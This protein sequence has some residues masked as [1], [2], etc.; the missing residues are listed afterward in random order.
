MHTIDPFIKVTREGVRISASPLCLTAVRQD[1]LHNAIPGSA[2]LRPACAPMAGM[3][4]SCQGLLPGRGLAPPVPLRQCSL[5]RSGTAFAGQ[6]VL[7]R[8]SARRLHRPRSQR[9]LALR[10]YYHYDAVRLLLAIGQPGL[11]AVSTSYCRPRSSDNVGVERPLARQRHGG[12]C[13][14]RCAASGDCS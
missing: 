5:N 3:A 8:P 7:S 9:V 2:V 12:E 13:H 11:R 6:C 14:C 10:N 4:P 1:Q